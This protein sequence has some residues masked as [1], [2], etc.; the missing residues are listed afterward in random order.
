VNGQVSTL[1][2]WALGL[3]IA[4]LTI[5]LTHVALRADPPKNPE[6]TKPKT[7]DVAPPTEDTG[8]DEQTWG[9]IKARYR[10]K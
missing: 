2:K 3:A 1:T 4:S 6:P 7:E 10:S 9:S 5:T 8:V